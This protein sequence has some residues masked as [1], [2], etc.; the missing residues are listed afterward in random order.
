M[1]R[2]DNHVGEINRY[3]DNQG[4]FFV[5]SIEAQ[6]CLTLLRTIGFFKMCFIDRLHGIS[7]RCKDV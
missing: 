7:E 3:N 6:Y 1:I 5:G 2:S 4:V